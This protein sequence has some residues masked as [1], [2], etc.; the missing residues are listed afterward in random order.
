MAAVFYSLESG[1]HVV[2]PNSMYWGVFSWTRQ[3][4]DRASISISYC[5]PAD[6]ASLHSAVTA[7]TSTDIVWV[8]TS[9]NPMMHVTDIHLATALARAACTLLVIDNT[10]PTPHFTRPLDLDHAL[11]V[12]LTVTDDSMHPES[13]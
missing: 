8:E 7:N 3:Y 4:C 11:T 5:A 6:A 1:A 2:L 9:S 13:D 12:G 10:V